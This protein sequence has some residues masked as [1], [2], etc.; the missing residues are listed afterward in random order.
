MTLKW[1]LLTRIVLIA[2][3]CLIV[4]SGLMLTLTHRNIFLETQFLAESID[5]QLEV[6][7]LMINAGSGQLEQ[8]PDLSLWR[9]TNGKA[10][11]CIRYQSTNNDNKRSLCKGPN[12]AAESP[13]FW[14]NLLFRRF[15]HI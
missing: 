4:G 3:L 8:F 1:H 2:I 14:F 11:L 6:Q 12:L 10:G 15:F 7:Y 13:P 5:R 9:E